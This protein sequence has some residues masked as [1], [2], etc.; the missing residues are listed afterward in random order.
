MEWL[1]FLKAN[2]FFHKRETQSNVTYTNEIHKDLIETFIHDFLSFWTAEFILYLGEHILSF[3]SEKDYLTDTVELCDEKTEISIEIKKNNIIPSDIV[4]KYNVHVYSK[5]TYLLSNLQ[6]PSFSVLEKFIF[7]KATQLTYIVIYD[8]PAYLN[9]VT[10]NFISIGSIAVLYTPFNE[11]EQQLKLINDRIKERNE[12][13]RWHQEISYLPPDV[14]YFSENSV[15]EISNF[16]KIKAISMCIAFLSLRTDYLEEDKQ[17]ESTFIGLK[18]I[19]FKLVIPSNISP[20]QIKKVFSLYTWAYSEKTTDKISLIQNI[21]NLHIKE[22]KNTDLKLFLKNS[23]EIYEMVQENYRVYIQKSVKAYLDERKQIEDFI[24]TTS[25]EISKQIS[26]I[27]DIVTKNLF[28]LLAT[29]ITAA[30][31][32]NKPENQAYIPW[33]LYIYGFFPSR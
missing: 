20:E 23:A 29:A 9:I 22:E 12:N 19:K 1:D 25:N 27:T 26:G 28:G 32:F 2:R 10:N 14:F 31:G 8:D 11:E 24:R 30:I 4:N 33:V 16:L 21:I 5:G 15:N 3:P 18:Q 7:K 6:E 17:Y 13:I